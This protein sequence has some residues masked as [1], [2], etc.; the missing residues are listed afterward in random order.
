MDGNIMRKIYKVKIALNLND[1]P[2]IEFIHQLGDTEVLSEEVVLEG[3]SLTVTLVARDGTKA[4]RKLSK[5]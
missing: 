1:I 2:T 5:I 3:A 4:V